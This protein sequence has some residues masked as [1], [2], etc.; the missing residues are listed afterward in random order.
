MMFL[1]WLS[2]F[3]G[4]AIFYARKKAEEEDYKNFPLPKFY[5]FGSVDAKERILYN[6]FN[7]IDQEVK[8]MIKVIQKEFHQTE[9][10]QQ[11]KAS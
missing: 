9:K 10:T 6:N 3:G 1:A 4:Q 7:K 8:N 2:A 5:D 11:Q